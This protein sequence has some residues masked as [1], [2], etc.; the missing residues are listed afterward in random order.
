MRRA[1]DT[2]LSLHFKDY[3]H[4]MYQHWY[5]MVQDHGEEAAWQQPYDSITMDDWTTICQHYEDPA[6]QVTHLNFFFRV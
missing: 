5:Q 4:H 6:Y 2:H 1:I 3:R